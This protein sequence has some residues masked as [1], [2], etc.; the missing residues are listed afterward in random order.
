M[1]Y[2]INFMTTLFGETQPLWVKL[3]VGWMMIINTLSIVFLK[4]RMGKIIFAVWNANGLT[5][6]VLFVLNGYNRMLG[7][8]HIIWWTPLIVYMYKMKDVDMEPKVYKV[9]YK[10]LFITICCSLIIDYIDLVRYFS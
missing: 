8:S 9:W 1:D 10:I 7:L 3:W 6:L 2:L 4:K 5:M